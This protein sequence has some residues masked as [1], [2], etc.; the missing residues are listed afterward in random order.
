MRWNDEYG[1]SLTRATS[2]Q[3]SCGDSRSCRHL[4]MVTRDG[5]AALRPS[6][7]PDGLPGGKVYLFS[8]LLARA[9]N[10]DEIAGAVRW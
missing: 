8:G 2:R 10:A 5:I 1:Q 6:Y 3:C 9:E 4:N 7:M